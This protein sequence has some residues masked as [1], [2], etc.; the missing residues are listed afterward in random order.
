[1]SCLAEGG[2]GLLVLPVLELAADGGVLL[3]EGDEE[4]VPA[5]EVEVLGP[6][7][8]VFLR[9]RVAAGGHIGG[10]L[11]EG[12]GVHDVQAA[13][14]QPEAGVVR[15]RGQERLVELDGEGQG[16]ADEIGVVVR[17]EDVGGGG[18]AGE[19]AGDLVHG[20]LLEGTAAERDDQDDGGDGRDDHPFSRSHLRA[21]HAGLLTPLRHEHPPLPLPSRIGPSRPLVKSGGSGARGPGRRSAWLGREVR[22]NKR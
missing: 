15:G 4:H 8:Q 20:Q 7:Q 9:L 14:A 18:G 22:L 5:A 3:L 10:R 16:L 13:G 12:V 17:A 6:G 1:M 21:P 2:H 11:D 19:H